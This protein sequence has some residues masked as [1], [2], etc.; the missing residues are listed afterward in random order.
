MKIIITALLLIVRVSYGYTWEKVYTFPNSAY[1]Q[2]IFD[3]DRYRIY[4]DFNTETQISSNL[5]NW[6]SQP[7]SVDSSMFTGDV[8]WTKICSITGNKTK[9]GLVS[10]FDSDKAWEEILDGLK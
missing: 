4:E 2:I 5:F 9:D 8:T 7:Q 6:V 1:K 3:S 10:D